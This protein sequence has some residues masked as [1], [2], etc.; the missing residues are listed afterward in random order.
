[1]FFLFHR[2]L[3]RKTTGTF[4]RDSG[5]GAASVFTGFLQGY[6]PRKQPTPRQRNAQAI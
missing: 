4:S 1:M 6:L 5:S 2:F 3:R